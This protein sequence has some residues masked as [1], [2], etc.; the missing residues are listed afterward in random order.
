[1]LSPRT[2]PVAAPA[3][4][5]LA[6]TLPLACAAHG[7]SS[8]PPPNAGS[9]GAAATSPAPPVEQALT[10]QAIP[11][12]DALFT[13]KVLGI[14]A[15]SA[16]RAGDTLVI[17]IPFTQ[18]A[19]ARCMVVRN[20]LDAGGSI[21]A[22]LARSPIGARLRDLGVENVQVSPETG[23]LS[24][25]AKRDDD[26]R[27]KIAGFRD[28]LK[29]F[30][31]TDE[32]ARDLAAFE[33][34]AE[35]LAA[36]L[37]PADAPPPPDVVQLCTIKIGDASPGVE[38]TEIAEDG[39]RTLTRITTLLAFHDG[40]KGLDLMEQTLDETA[41]EGRASAISAVQL[42][43]G[44]TDLKASLTRD[45][46]GGY[47]ATVAG[48]RGQRYDGPFRVKDASGLLST[49][50]VRQQIQ[51]E[52][53]EGSATQELHIEG[54]DPLEAPDKSTVRVL[55]RGASPGE[56]TVTDGARVSRQVFDRDG[57]LQSA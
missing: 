17:W 41:F 32:T 2:V 8:P 13:G 20:E 49:G 14:A 35:S 12:P 50:G 15:P 10:W 56:V 31:C 51:R 47:H 53:I 18:Q 36:W 5:L 37:Q 3:T 11:F 6:L 45:A 1:M 30:V 25:V 4:L 40:P 7:P 21:E 54:F 26:T 34:V 29:T 16:A 43:G 33:R 48:R 38:R 28:R 42:F 23:T 39:Q 22:L 9:V 44:R 46:T 52:L 55:A 19:Q 57:F 24:L 27:V